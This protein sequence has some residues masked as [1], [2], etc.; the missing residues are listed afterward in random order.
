MR[1]L[2]I[3]VVLRLDLGQSSFNLVENA[4][5]AGQLALF[6]TR[7]TFYDIL[8]RACTEIFSSCRSWVSIDDANFGP[9][10]WCQK[11][12]KGQGSSWL[13]TAGTVVNGLIY[14]LTI[15]YL[16]YGKYI[17]HDITRTRSVETDPENNRGEWPL[18]V[19]TCCLVR[20]DINLPIKISFHF[21]HFE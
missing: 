7:I 9:N 18:I 13:V 14:R 12:K 11:W 10:W 3:L 19:A 1:F 4:F 15:D 2:D 17:S 21:S 20:Q 5:A 8:A 16:R 6:A